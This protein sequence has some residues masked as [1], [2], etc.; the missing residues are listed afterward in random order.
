DVARLQLLPGR[1]LAPDETAEALTLVPQ[2]EDW[3]KSV[4][5]YAYQQANSGVQI[6][7]F[8]LVAKRD[9][10]RKWADEKETEAELRGA[11]VD[12]FKHTLRSP[13]DL[14]KEFDK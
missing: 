8:K 2:L 13:A 14:E 10:N 12:L 5:S 11:G 4:E 1:K 6:P 3:I 9:G 7:G